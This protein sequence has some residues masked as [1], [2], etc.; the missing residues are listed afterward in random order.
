MENSSVSLNNIVLNVNKTITGEIAF[1]PGEV[2]RGT[3]QDIIQDNLVNIVI[4][5]KLI[6]AITEVKVNPGQDLHL[7]VDSQKGGK[8]YLK[9]LSADML[10]KIE[11]SNLAATLID[12]GISPKP[13]H[14]AKAR[15]LWQ[16]QLP[17]NKENL[18]QMDK[19]LGILGGNNPRNLEIAGFALNKQINNPDSLKSLLQFITQGDI[20]KSIGL[21][22]KAIQ[23]I[24]TA[25]QSA[26][27][28]D[29]SYGVPNSA[30]S[31]NVNDFFNRFNSSRAL[32][33][34]SARNQ[35]VLPG[36][37]DQIPR[38][39]VLPNNATFAQKA[40]EPF[41]SYL[42]AAP[43]LQSVSIINSEA[44]A[45]ILNR[46]NSLLNTFLD[47]LDL[48]PAIDAKNLKNQIQQ[49]IAQD[50]DLNRVFS[51]LKELARDENISSKFSFIK[52]LP[53]Q[54]EKLEQEL[55]GQRLLNLYNR[56]TA[57][58]NEQV[59]FSF[60]IKY[61]DEY[62]LCQLKIKKDNSARNTLKPDK[63]QI[64]VS[65][66][67]EKLGLVLFHVS[68]QNKRHLQIQGI[69]NTQKVCNY[70]NNNMGYLISNLQSAGFEVQN[71][72][73]RVSQNR[74]EN[75]SLKPKFIATPQTVKP[76]RID[77]KI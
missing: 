1:R 64:A 60:P 51:L 27:L 18:L 75:Y 8:T 14:L 53:L 62:K 69:V 46:I 6:E 28:I 66:D 48:E 45:A 47:V 70:F 59:Y 58:H 65:L 31:I 55:T 73:I 72:G 76:I 61:G 20:S 71:L 9:V 7:L 44:E 17:I 22:L 25:V 41:A 26:S 13:E 68:W 52:E 42:P 38:S 23:Q 2:L 77:I 54:L 33:A 15:K 21:L 74:Q 67:T 11:S 56:N 39:E 24:D 63:L 3:V 12:L 30:K 43:Q 16:Y 10:N 49:R 35:P 57:D 32:I 37:K 29:S 19:S 36:A 4:K 5:G 40:S 34:N 50:T